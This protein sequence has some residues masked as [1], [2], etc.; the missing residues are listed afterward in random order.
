M[1][2]SDADPNSFDVATGLREHKVWFGRLGLMFS[3]E[4]RGGGPGGGDFNGWTWLAG[5]RMAF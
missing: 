5:V 3:C 4:V 2:W 1:P